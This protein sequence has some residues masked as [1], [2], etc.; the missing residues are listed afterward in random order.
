[1]TSLLQAFS[2][3]SLS[4]LAF[5]GGF[6][7]EAAAPRAATAQDREAAEYQVIVSGTVALFLGGVGVALFALAHAF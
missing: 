1:M 6:C 2:R 5:A 7:R 4:E 3:H